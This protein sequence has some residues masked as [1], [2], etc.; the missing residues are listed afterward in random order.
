[1][2]GPLGTRQGLGLYLLAWLV[3][4]AALGWLLAAATSSSLAA[5]LLFTVPLVLVYAV[6][7][8]FSVWYLCR[9]HPLGTT[10]AWRYNR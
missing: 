9:A 8:S 5:A 3:F 6:A 1:M 4:G 10:P 7:A 2:Q